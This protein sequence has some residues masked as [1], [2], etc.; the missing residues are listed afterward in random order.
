MWFDKSA[1]NADDSL[2]HANQSCS[3]AAGDQTLAKTRF[4]CPADAHAPDGVRC[5]TAKVIP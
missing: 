3:T 1:V 5:Y 2:Q 4:C